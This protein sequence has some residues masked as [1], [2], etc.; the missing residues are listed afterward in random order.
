MSK[1]R[2]IQEFKKILQGQT[3]EM[4]EVQTHWVVTKSVDWDTKR[5]V[6]TGL[7]DGLDFSNVLLGLGSVYL[8]PTPKSKCLIGLINNNPA[9]AF[10][11]EAEEIEAVEIN[12]KAGFKTVLNNGK[13]LVKNEQV[14]FFSIMTDLADLLKQLKV[15][16]PNGPSGTPLPA[17]IQAITKFETDL[18]KILE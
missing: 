14:S 17:S 2:N 8:K 4:I 12:D 10:L 5:M 3:K 11:I 16:T 7:L 9:S 18:G 13:L 1:G 15:S 6:A